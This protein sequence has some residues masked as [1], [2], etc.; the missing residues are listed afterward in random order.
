MCDDHILPVDGEQMRFES[1]G[2]YRAGEREIEIP[3]GTELVAIVPSL[4]AGWV[5]W[6]PGYEEEIAS[7]IRWGLIGDREQL[8]DLNPACRK[9]SDRGWVPFNTLLLMDKSGNAYTFIATTGAELH[10]IGR[11]S[12]IYGD[13]ICID[14]SVLPVVRLATRI[15][16]HRGMLKIHRPFFEII[17]WTRPPRGG[18]GRK[19]SPLPPNI[20][21][22][23]L[24]NV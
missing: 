23:S 1:V 18:R 24:L 8:G 2:R 10:A 6:R 22:P 21:A 20:D 14:K 19:R 9:Y 13:A 15:E 5:R 17:S 3:L 12:S 11:L 4:R 7:D 16:H